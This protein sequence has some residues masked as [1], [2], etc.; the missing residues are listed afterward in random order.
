MEQSTTPTG[1]LTRPVYI[2]RV[3]IAVGITLVVLLLT[4][5]LG[6]AFG[7]FLRVMAALLIALPLRAGGDWLH[8]RLG[9]P[10]WLGLLLVAL[11]VLGLLAGAGWLF[12]SRLDAQVGQLEQQLPS[13]YH[14]L[15][16]R[17][18]S[19]R[20][21]K[22]LAQENF[23]FSNVMGGGS[24]WLGRATGLFSSTIG[25]LADLYVIVFLALFIAI[26]PKLYRAGIVMLVPQTGRPRANQVLDQISTTLVKWFVGQLF[27]MTMVGLLSALGLWLLGLPAVAALA[28]FAGLITFIP[29]LGPLLSM[30]PAVL[31]A[32]FNGGP[33]MALY[34][35]GLYLLV[36]AIESNLLTPLAQRSLI[37]MPPALI[38]IAQLVIGSYAGILGLILATPIM[39][40]LIVLVKMLYVQDVLKDKSV[41]VGAGGN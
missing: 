3:G 9:V 33:Q 31:V 26:Q 41:Q 22:W 1:S 38:F 23:D 35:V 20:W 25:V 15:L 5:L 10:A 24:A 28:L 12:S 6:T 4:G 36:Q 13:A 32:F 40:M 34:V 19:T 16:Q 27:S 37:A 14:S 7:V 11:L 29:N 2:Q 17:V 39:A 18:G 21:G 8:R 30:L